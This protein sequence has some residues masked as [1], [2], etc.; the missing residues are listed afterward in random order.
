MRRVGYLADLISLTRPFATSSLRDFVATFSWRLV[1]MT[2]FRFHAPEGPLPSMCW[3]IMCVSSD[4]LANL[5]AT[6]FSRSR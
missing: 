5:V 3:Y 4:S 6:D 1:F 2:K